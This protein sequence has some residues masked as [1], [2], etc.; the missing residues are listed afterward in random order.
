MHAKNET[1]RHPYR[2]N[3]P[4]Q[5]IRALRKT[6]GY[7]QR[8]FAQKVNMSAAGLC[9]IENGVNVHPRKIVEISELLGIHPKELNFFN[10]STPDI[11][12]ENVN[13]IKKM[14]PNWKEVCKELIKE[15]K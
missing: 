9:K 3:I 5:K 8:E 2:Y 6:M 1:I 13:L 14:F 11:V 4:G 10:P 12:C 7:N 15:L